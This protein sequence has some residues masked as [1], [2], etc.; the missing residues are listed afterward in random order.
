MKEESENDYF[1]SIDNLAGVLRIDPEDVLDHPSLL[2]EVYEP[3]FEIPL[4][5]QK[6]FDPCSR[7]TASTIYE[8]EDFKSVVCFTEHRCSEGVYDVK[9]HTCQNCIRPINDNALIQYWLPVTKGPELGEEFRNN[10]NMIMLAKSGMRYA[11]SEKFSPEREPESLP[12]EIKR[13]PEQIEKEFD[14]ELIRNQIDLSKKAS[15]YYVRVP[16]SFA[17][18][19]SLRRYTQ[20]HRGIGT[21]VPGNTRHVSEIHH[22]S[23]ASCETVREFNARRAAR[24]RHKIKDREAYERTKSFEKLV[25]QGQQKV[26]AKVAELAWQYTVLLADS[27]TTRGENGIRMPRWVEQYVA[28]IWAL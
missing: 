23:D 7:E 1:E 8:E 18:L 24:K 2:R 15:Y 26:S 11:I 16:C 13:L 6:H 3:K 21:D 22:M 4:R 5:V 19:V 20:V 28:T 17:A 10:K 25:H 27:A 14:V 9:P 12:V